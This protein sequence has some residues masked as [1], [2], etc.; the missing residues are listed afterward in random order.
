M[1]PN[2]SILDVVEAAG[3]GVR[4]S[5]AEGMSGIYGSARTS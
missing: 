1:P 5:C 2:R 4:S 3:V